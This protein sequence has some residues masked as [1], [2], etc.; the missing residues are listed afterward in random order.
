M[1]QFRGCVPNYSVTK[2]DAK[3]VIKKIL[4]NPPKRIGGKNNAND[5]NDGINATKC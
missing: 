2:S 5:A 3:K 4:E 1:I